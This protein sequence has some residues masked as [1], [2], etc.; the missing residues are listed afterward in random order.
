MKSKWPKVPK[1]LSPEQEAIKKDWMV[2]WH[3]IVPTKFSYTEKFN[4]IGGLLHIPLP[5]NCR[6]LEVGAGLG[7]QVEFENLSR[8]TYFALDLR[9]DMLLKCKERF[10]EVQIIQGDIQDRSL[11]KKEC[12][13]RVIAIHVLE[14]LLDLPEALRNIDHLLK[15][16]GFFEVIIPLEGSLFYSLARRVSSQRE[17]EK[18]FKIPYNW[19]IESEHVNTY[20]EVLEELDKYFII[21]W[22]K[23]FPLN[24]PLFFCNLTLGLRYYKK[25]IRD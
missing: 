6:T 5:P 24:I 3:E 16:E 19:C 13:D 18:R 2:H 21:S 14:H 1:V 9:Q 22:R 15:P 25:Y 12:F 4:H 10:P 8:Q 20:K 7:S 11:F 23:F 17:F